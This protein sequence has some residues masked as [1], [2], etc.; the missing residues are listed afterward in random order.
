MVSIYPVEDIRL[1]D[2]YTILHEPISSFNLMERA[3][4]A[5]FIRLTKCVDLKK[6]KSIQIF[7]GIG[8]NGGDGLVIARKLLEH[9]FHPEIF[10]V[11]FSSNW[12]KDF[13]A[14]YK[15]INVKAERLTQDHCSFNIDA[16]VLVIDAIFGSGLD[17]PVEGYISEIIGRINACN[18]CCVAIDV[19]SGMAAD[20]A[21]GNN[22]QNTIK[23]DYTLTFQY[24]KMAFMLQEYIPFIGKLERIDIGLHPD[25]ELHHPASMKFI[26]AIDVRGLLKTRAAE[27][28][29]GNFGHALLHLG[30]KGKYGAAILAARACMRSGVGL[31]SMHCPKSAHPM[32]HTAVPEAMIVEESEA[33]E[34]GTNL[35]FE[36]HFT[37][38]L[39]CGIG[40]SKKTK[41]WLEEFLKLQDAPILLDADAINIL[42]QNKALL[43]LV[44]NRSILT[45]HIGEFKRLVGECEDAFDRLKKQV[46]FAQKY[47]VILVLKGKHTSI[48]E[49]NGNVYFN[50]TGNA[51][52][53]TA[54][55]GDVLT[56]I[57]TALLAQGYSSKNAAILGVYL[58]GLAGDFAAKALGMESM[59]ASDIIEALPQAFLTL[60]S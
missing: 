46:E 38:G 19:P 24:L 59:I 54:G 56:G 42:A 36:S 50:S 37:H 41:M 21:L 44:P 47:S 2:Q 45:P 22:E 33:N 25:F 31:L 4:T 1:A 51:G 53:A 58:H 7:C 6:F 9:G 17:R 20:K 14:N 13:R 29:K 18:E 40:Q 15:R 27:A 5:A 3:A 30:S 8:N 10:I 55:S 49:E 34:L 43:S 28:Y 39:G 26:E 16:N 48:A 60:K 12:S 23:A 32:L 11:D 35:S 57:L 52:M